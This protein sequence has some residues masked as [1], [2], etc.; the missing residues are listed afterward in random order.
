MLEAAGAQMHAARL[1]SLFMPE[2]IPAS[3]FEMDALTG[4]DR[5]VKPGSHKGIRAN[6]RCTGGVGRARLDYPVERWRAD[7]TGYCQRL[8]V[9]RLAR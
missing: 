3:M 1:L 4:I 8:A 9:R 2:S 6:P 7:P 5:R